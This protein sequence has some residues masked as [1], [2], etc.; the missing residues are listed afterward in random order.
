ML[1]EGNFGFRRLTDEDLVA[2]EDEK[3]GEEKRG[4]DEDDIVASEF[5]GESWL[6]IVRFIDGEESVG[7]ERRPANGLVYNDGHD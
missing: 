4:R 2:D 3:G 1:G 6:A 5:H 7:F